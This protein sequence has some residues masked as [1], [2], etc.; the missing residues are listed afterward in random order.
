MSDSLNLQ[1]L[2]ETIQLLSVGN[3]GHSVTPTV[4]VFLSV[5]GKQKG[6]ELDVGVSLNIIPLATPMSGLTCPLPIKLVQRRNTSCLKASFNSA[7][8][9]LFRPTYPNLFG[10]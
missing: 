10:S 1:V 3:S 2:F 6:V 7:K 5:K 8:K 9:N 4:L